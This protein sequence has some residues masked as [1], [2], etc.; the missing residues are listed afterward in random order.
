MGTAV[1]HVFWCWLFISCLKLEV[2]GAALA[3]N[4]T[5]ITTFIVQEI[6]VRYIAYQCFKYMMVPFF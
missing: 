2:L 6:Y 3:I 1:L 4:I 5:Y